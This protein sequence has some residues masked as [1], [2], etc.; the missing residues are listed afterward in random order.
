VHLWVKSEVPFKDIA[1]ISS[2]W[3]DGAILCVIVE[4]AVAA[5]STSL[6]QTE[7]YRAY[8]HVTIP[9]IKLGQKLAQQY[10]GVQ[11]VRI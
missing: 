3:S 6:Y 9:T 11:P 2:V 1:N 4:N 8:G 10:L 7:K 5:N